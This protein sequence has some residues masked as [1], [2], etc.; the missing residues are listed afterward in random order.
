MAVAGS[1]HPSSGDQR[2]VDSTL[3]MPWGL[4]TWILPWRLRT[5]LVRLKMSARVL[6]LT[7]PPGECSTAWA[8]NP[9]LPTLGGARIT[10]FSC[11]PTRTFR[12][13][14]ARPR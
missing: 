6:E 3:P 12:P 13:Y 11:S 14:W 9:D 8:R 1:S 4:R 10:R 2:N 5:P 7:T